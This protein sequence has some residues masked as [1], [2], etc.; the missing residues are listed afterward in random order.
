L[1]IKDEQ[2]EDNTAS[3]DKVLKVIKKESASIKMAVS[4]LEAK[5]LQIQNQPITGIDLSSDFVTV[6]DAIGKLELLVESMDRA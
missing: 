4:V 5:F 6:K 2:I 3:Y 1:K